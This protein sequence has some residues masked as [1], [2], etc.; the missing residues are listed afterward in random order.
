MCIIEHYSLGNQRT[1]ISR[2][3]NINEKLGKG[4]V[5]EP[6]LSDIASSRTTLVLSCTHGV[7]YIH[8]YMLHG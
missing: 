2:G 3:L 1:E 7:K 6:G 4:P 5:L 8:T